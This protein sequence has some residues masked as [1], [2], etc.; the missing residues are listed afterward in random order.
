MVS[1]AALLKRNPLTIAARA[2]MGENAI[3]PDRV[4]ID[5]IRAEPIGDKSVQVRAEVML[6]MPADK[7]WRAIEEAEA[8]IAVEDAKERRLASQ[9]QVSIDNEGALLRGEDL[10]PESDIPIPS[11]DDPGF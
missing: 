8:Q 10:E 5:S 11:D 4:D 1:R 6:T 3:N 2:F 9:A 7:F